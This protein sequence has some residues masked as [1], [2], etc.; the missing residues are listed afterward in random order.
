MPYN[1]ELAKY[2][3]KI[4]KSGYLLELMYL[5]FFR[6]QVISSNMQFDS[7]AGIS[8]DLIM[9][10]VFKQYPKLKTIYIDDLI[11]TIRRMIK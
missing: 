9:K 11:D 4:D 1:D 10:N 3:K 6:L 2:I 5:G 8:S 7:G